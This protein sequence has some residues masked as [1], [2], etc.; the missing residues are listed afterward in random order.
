MES[1]IITREKIKRIIEATDVLVCLI[2][3]ST[4]HNKWGNWEVNT[5]AYLEKKLIGIRLHDIYRDQVPKAL[6][7]NNAKIISCDIDSILSALK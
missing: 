1:S 3:Y 5:A 7:D 2:G 4:T 6:E